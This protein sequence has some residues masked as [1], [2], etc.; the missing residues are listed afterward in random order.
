MNVA[1][2]DGLQLSLNSDQSPLEKFSAHSAG[3]KGMSAEKRQENRFHSCYAV[4]QR[5]LRYCEVTH[6]RCW[7]GFAL[8]GAIL[9]SPGVGPARRCRAELL[10]RLDFGG[11]SY[12]HDGRTPK[13]S[14]PAFGVQAWIFVNVNLSK[15]EAVVQPSKL[16]KGKRLGKVLR[17]SQESARA[18]GHA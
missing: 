14:L 9:N 13:E 7:K 4:K 5:Y 3:V 8:P 10:M 2:K 12:G 11:I 18:E 17:G 6:P 15:I 16:Q 1:S